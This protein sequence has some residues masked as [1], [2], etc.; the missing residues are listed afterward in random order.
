MLSVQEVNS[1]E[2]GLP[3]AETLEAENLAL[4]DIIDDLKISQHLM[5]IQL[6]SQRKKIRYLRNYI[7]NTLK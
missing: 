4:K 6:E 5:N 2:T 7:S 1:N 3:V